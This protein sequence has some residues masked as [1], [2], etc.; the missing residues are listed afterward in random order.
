M[1]K[2]LI[3]FTAVT[4]FSLPMIPPAKA[5]LVVTDPPNTIQNI[6]QVIGQI[7]Q[8]SNEVSQIANQVSQIENQI[9]QLALIG[10]GDFSVILGYVAE[11]NADISNLLA[12]ADTLRYSLASIQG[13][14][15]S[16]YPQGASQWGAFNLD[17]INEKREDWDQI[18]TKA[19]SGAARAQTSLGRIQARNTAINNLMSAAQASD[20]D[21]RQAQINNQINGTLVHGI[22]DLVAV[23]TTASRLAMIQAQTEVAEREAAREQTRRRY[24]DYHSAGTTSSALN[25]FPSL[26]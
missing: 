10:E 26:Q 11:Q 5:Q 3:T 22:N 6:I 21:V 13:E 8:I 9:R 24:E 7:T 17:E 23:E 4:M 25:A 16:E 19:G 12:T 2:A 20:G 14:I 18:V 1:K 15:D